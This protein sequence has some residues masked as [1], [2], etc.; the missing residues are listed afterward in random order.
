[1]VWKLLLIWLGIVKVNTLFFVE[2]TKEPR[3]DIRV[4]AIEYVACVLKNI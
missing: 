3:I 1:M 2:T 4:K